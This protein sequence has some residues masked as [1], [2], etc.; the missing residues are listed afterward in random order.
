MGR[1]KEGESRPSN[2]KGCK[3][4]L[5]IKKWYYREGFYFCS[6]RCWSDSKDKIREEVEK[7]REEREKLKQEEAQKVAETVVSKVEEVAS[8]IFL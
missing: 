8:K 7:A 5:S 4:R 2:C 6:K 3:K 1:V